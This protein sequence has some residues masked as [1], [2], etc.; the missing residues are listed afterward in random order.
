MEIYFQTITLF[1]GVNVNRW[2]KWAW[3]RELVSVGTK[4]VTCN[5]RTFFLC[6]LTFLVFQS[7]PANHCHSLSPTPFSVTPWG[8]QWCP[9]L[10]PCRSEYCLENVHLVHFYRLRLATYSANN[11]VLRH[12]ELKC[13][14]LRN[15]ISMLNQFVWHYDTVAKQVSAR[16]S[17][18][19]RTIFII[20]SFT[21]FVPCI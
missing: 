1:E 5:Q 17:S 16:L 6:L 12:R 19:P 18:C 11:P 3:G 15:F 2:E 8:L 21:Y 14:Y 4:Q 9:W 10:L 13:S 7:C 20:L